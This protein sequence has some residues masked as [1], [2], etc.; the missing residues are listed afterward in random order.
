MTAAP[1]FPPEPIEPWVSL[2]WQLGVSAFAGLVAMLLAWIVIVL[3]LEIYDEWIGGPRPP[4][5]WRRPWCTL[6]GHD[7]RPRGPAAVV[8]STCRRC[9]AAR[10]EGMPR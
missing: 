9:G 3:L 2:A 4:A 10:P 8:S 7:D 1:V 6:V 5:L